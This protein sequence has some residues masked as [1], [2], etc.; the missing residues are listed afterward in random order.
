MA[1]VFIIA[2]CFSFQLRIEANVA[3][4]NIKVFSLEILELKISKRFTGINK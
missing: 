1:L 4:E 3:T 2:C